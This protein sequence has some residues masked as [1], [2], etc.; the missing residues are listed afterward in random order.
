MT[1]LIDQRAA[2]SPLHQLRPLGFAA[3]GYVLFLLAVYWPQPRYMGFI[4]ALF[5]VHGPR[6][7]QTVWTVTTIA[8]L[9]PQLFYFVC[10][11]LHLLRRSLIDLVV[12][13]ILRVLAALSLIDMVLTPLL[14]GALGT[15]A[16][17]GVFFLVSASLFAW[18]VLLCGIGCRIADRG[19]V[20]ALLPARVPGFFIGAVIAWS[21]L[22]G[23]MAAGQAVWLAAGQPYCIAGPDN[24]VRSVFDL[25]G[26]N[27]FQA[28][29]DDHHET[30][31][32]HAV[33]VV[34]TTDEERHAWNWSMTRMSWSPLRRPPPSRTRPSCRLVENFLSQLAWF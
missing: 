19:I 7:Q 27:L 18:D 10:A 9:V 22:S 32:H 12:L 31:D 3:I 5:L 25:R 2:E 11:P 15:D 13:A 4:W 21:I 14:T 16:N 30:L 24:D 17:F 8:P 29:A 28:R 26:S 23:L 1:A 34:A 33:L 20:M 6:D